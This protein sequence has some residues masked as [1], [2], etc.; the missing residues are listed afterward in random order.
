MAVLFSVFLFSSGPFGKIWALF[1]FVLASLTDYWDGAIARRRHEESQFGKLMDPIADKLLTLSAFINFWLLG[2]IPLWMAAVV[3][4]RDVAVTFARLGM[5]PQ[6]KSQG[7]AWIGKQKTFLQIVYIIAVLL[8]LIA[9]RQGP[10]RPAWD[11]TAHHA[12]L[13]GMMAIVLITVW[14][15]A[16]VLWPRG[17]K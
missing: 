1:Y 12:I 14:S 13:T 16:Q 8:Y 9:R 17:R 15:G 7:A 2:L 5:K 6:D 10:W 4:A 11:Q 3:L